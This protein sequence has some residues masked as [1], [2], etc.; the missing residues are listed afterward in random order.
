MIASI[1]RVSSFH[2]TEWLVHSP[3]RAGLGVGRPFGDD[4]LAYFTERLDPEVTLRALAATLKQAKRNKAFQ[5]S[6]RIGLALD[7]TG[8]GRPISSSSTARTGSRSGTP[9]TSI[10][11]KLSTGRRYGRSAT[12]NTSPTERSSRPTG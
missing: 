9:M 2:H 3:A 4:A 1:L 8:A 11:G 5:N 12:A 10:P 7:G 6:P